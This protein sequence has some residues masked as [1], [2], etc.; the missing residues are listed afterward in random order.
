MANSDAD[1]PKASGTGTVI[2]L[3]LASVLAAGGGIALGWTQF[4][5]KLDAAPAN[6]KHH[7]GKARDEKF[8]EGSRVRELVPITTNLSGDPPVWIRLEASLLLTAAAPPSEEDEVLLRTVSEDVVA[9]L[10]TMTLQQIQGPSG[11]LNLREDLDER[12]RIR[13]EGKAQELIVQAL[14]VE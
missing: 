3:V 1:T 2:G 4:G 8:V 14:I 11:F 9:Y 10:R 12:V 13:S 7:D 5:Q 6:A